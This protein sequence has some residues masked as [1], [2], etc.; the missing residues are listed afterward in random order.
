MQEKIAHL[1]EHGFVVFDFQD[2]SV[3]DYVRMS[4]EERLAQLIGKKI[5]LE[6]YHLSIN[7]DER[8]SELQIELTKFYREQK[9]ARKIFHS[10]VNFFQKIVGLDLLSQANPYLRMTR[11]GK[12]QDNIGYHRDTFYGGS[13]YELSVLV[14][15]V[16]VEKES[17]LSVM[18][19]S[20][21]LPEKL[22]PTEQIQNPDTTVTKGSSKHQLGFL[23]APKLMDPAIEKKMEPIALKRGQALMFFLSTVHGSVVNQ[24]Q[25]TRWSSDMRILNALAGVD[26][27]ARPDYYELLSL[28]PVTACARKYYAQNQEEIYATL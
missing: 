2:I 7:D 11:P 16:D 22:F 17:S 23:Y 19:G 28:S 1:Q 25:I 4:L 15:F 12:P 10:Q 3:I 14:P 21:C 8:H 13:P 6:E 9:F 24:G 20:H 27:S 18:P 5:P 26:L